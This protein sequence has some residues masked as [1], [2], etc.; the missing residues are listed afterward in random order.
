MPTNLNDPPSPQLALRVDAREGETVV[1]CEGWLTAEFAP[2]FKAEI[3]SLIPGAKRIV[4]DLM[5]V[6]FMDSW[7]IGALV[8]VYVSARTAGC[9]IRV[10]GMSKHVRELLK[11]THLL[12]VLGDTGPAPTKL[13]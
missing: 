3:K 7:G 11:L 12:S 9:E 13:P 5:P 2:K 4:L 8:G 6:T 1:V 10:A